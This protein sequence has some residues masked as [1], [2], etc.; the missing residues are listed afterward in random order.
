M[1]SLEEESYVYGTMNISSQYYEHMFTVPG[2]HVY[3]TMNRKKDGREGNLPREKGKIIK[4][5]GKT[6]Q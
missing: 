3:G 1:L 2:T 5:E 6:F 4:E